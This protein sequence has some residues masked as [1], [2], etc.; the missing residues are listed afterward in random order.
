MISLR[1]ATVWRNQ[2]FRTLLFAPEGG[3]ISLDLIAASGEFTA[4]WIDPVAG[5]RSPAGPVGGGV[6]HSFS[7]PS[8][9]AV[10]LFLQRSSQ[11]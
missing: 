2:V 11:P 4:E 6:R 7:A 10:V 1:P 5:T 8:D 9:T 3:K